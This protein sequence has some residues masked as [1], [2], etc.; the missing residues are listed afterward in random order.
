MADAYLYP[1]SDLGTAGAGAWSFSSGTSFFPL[2]DDPFDTPNDSDYVQGSSGAGGTL[3][4]CGVTPMPTAVGIAGVTALVRANNAGAGAGQEMRHGITLNGVDYF[5]SWN[6]ISSGTFNDFTTAWAV[7]PGNGAPFTKAQLDDAQIVVE[8]RDAVA[9]A[10]SVRISQ[11]YLH[12]VYQPPSAGRGAAQG[13]ASQRLR[14]YRGELEV[15]RIETSL[16]VL[17]NELMDDISITH[18]EGPHPLGLG[19]GETE[20]LAGTPL[21]PSDRRLH[22]LREESIDLNSMTVTVTTRGRRGFLCGFWATWESRRSSASTEDGTALLTAG[23]TITY[24]RASKAWHEDPGS[25]LVVALANDAQPLARDGML[26]DNLATN[27]LT[28]SA[29]VAGTLTGLTST[30]TGVNGSAA[31]AELDPPQPLFDPSVSRYA[32]MLTAG[33]PHAADNILAWPITTIYSANSRLRLSFDYMNAGAT[34]LLWRL[35][36]S[37]DG[38][39]WNDSTQA[40]GAGPINNTAPL[41]ATR[42]RLISERIPSG[43]SNTRFTFSWLQGT[44]GA[45]GR[46]DRVYQVQLEQNYWATSRIVTEDTS[47]TRAIQ[48]YAVENVAGKRAIQPTSGTIWFEFIPQW[49]AADMN[50]YGGSPTFVDMTYDASNWLRLFYNSGAPN[51]L[52]FQYRAGGVTVLASVP[53]TPVRGQLYRVACR[54]TSAAGE[55]AWAGLAPRTLSVFVDDLK[56]TDNT[57]AADASETS[58]NLYLAGDSAGNAVNG[59]M[60][61]VVITPEVLTDEEILA[62]YA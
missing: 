14:Q 16:A 5:G 54:W 3:F 48:T 46:L 22:Q 33:T 43:A 32:Y 4:R 11:A 9:A 56:G 59:H 26:L 44:G 21:G 36:R 42:A 60:R 10:D 31:A 30:G 2:I 37:A 55:L 51:R 35:L 29:A 1:D 49:A 18:P 8:V 34:A 52:D 50:A 27:S 24:A 25:G 62:G 17:D 15:V 61:K 45:S 53:W 7:H 13:V 40:F 38:L 39:Y 6:P 41:S 57:R 28:R 19:W 23:G 58:A 47:V 20:P 12:P